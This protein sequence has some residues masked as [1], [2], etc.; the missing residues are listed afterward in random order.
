MSC[1]RL[2]WFFAATSMPAERGLHVAACLPAVEAAT[3]GVAAPDRVD[4]GEV[5]VATPVA[6]VDE[7]QQPRAVRA[8]LGAEDAGGGPPLVA[9]L[10]QVGVDVRAHVV[11]VGGLVQLGDGPDRVVEQRDDVRERVAEEAGDADRDVDAGPAQLVQ[12]HDL[13]AGD[14]A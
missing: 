11:D 4:L 3:V 13:E 14:A 2:S 8:R 12:R 7:R 6:R 1:S 10:G 9:V 5:G